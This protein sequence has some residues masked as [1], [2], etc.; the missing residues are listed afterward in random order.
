MKEILVRKWEESGLVKDKRLLE[1]FK[2]LRRE[3]F[4]LGDSIREAYGDYAL[5]IHCGQTISQ[6]I[7]IMIMTQALELKPGN[8]VLEVG[9]GSGY[10]AA[11]IAE[12]VKPKGR[13]ITTE[14]V[15]GLVDFAKKN[16]KNAGIRNVR[17][18]HYD[19]SGGY[20]KEAPYDKII[21]TAAA[22]KIPKPLV[23]QLK[24]GGIL[25][26]PVGPSYV[27]EMLKVRKVSKEKLEIENLGDFVFV[28]LTGRYGNKN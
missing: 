9:A 8:K 6:P 20:E 16:L 11:I 7:T 27:Q 18:I 1:V 26:I 21:V 14:I 17:V 10:Q 4:I 13:V 22:P 2:K 19:G 25:V 3:D 15:P 5:P 28:P 23:Q 24:T 12:M